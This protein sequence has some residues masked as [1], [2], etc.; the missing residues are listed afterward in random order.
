MPHRCRAALP[1]H[2]AVKFPEYLPGDEAQKYFA[3]GNNEYPVA[4]LQPLAGPGDLKRE[5]VPISAR[6][7]VNSVGRA[8]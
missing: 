2:G 4:P 8:G 6:S 1:S 5:L 3:D 7:L